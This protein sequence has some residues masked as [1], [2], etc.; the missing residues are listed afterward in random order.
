MATAGGPSPGTCGPGAWT[1]SP[2]LGALREAELNGE[3][4]M[5]AVIWMH[6]L[7]HKHKV[8][9][10][11]GDLDYK[12]VFLSGAGGFRSGGLVD[13]GDRIAVGDRTAM[14]YASALQGRAV[15]CQG[16]TTTTRWR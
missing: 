11:P 2:P 10:V 4:Q 7:I 12:Q 16:S 15:C 9:P 6:E 3:Q 14:A 13:W 5:A 1:V 8:C